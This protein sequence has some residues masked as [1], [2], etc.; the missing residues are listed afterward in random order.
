MPA[1]WEPHKQVWMGWPLRP[2]NWRNH[3]GPA[4]DA[5]AAVA[6]AILE[7]E[8]VTICAPNFPEARTSLSHPCPSM[9]ACHVLT[10]DPWGPLSSCTRRPR[11]SPR[12][13]R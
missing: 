6:E 4:Q 3:A 1:E 8:P 11:G 13:W 2:D 7:F 12:P 5:Y 10:G 9:L